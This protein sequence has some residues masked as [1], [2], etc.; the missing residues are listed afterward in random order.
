MTQTYVTPPE[1]AKAWGVDPAKVLHWI[2]SGELVA[3]N[4]A[5]RIG[6]KPRYRISATDLEAFM[7][8]R[9]PKPAPPIKRRKKQSGVT[10]YY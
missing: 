4:L 10:E 8:R 7:Q 3:T 2:K 5:T 6:G 1:I 9:Q